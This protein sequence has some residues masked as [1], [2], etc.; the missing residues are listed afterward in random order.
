MFPVFLILDTMQTLDV[1]WGKVTAGSIVN[2]FAKA[3]IS[4]EQDAA[5]KDAFQVLQEQ[6]DALSVQTPEFFPEG[7]TAN[8]IVFAD[9]N[10]INTEPV[11]FDD[12]II[13][14]SM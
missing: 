8:D 1:A 10:V 4:K 5:L 6:L 13:N 9:D 11:M 7:P 3:G 14:D 2:C 12:E